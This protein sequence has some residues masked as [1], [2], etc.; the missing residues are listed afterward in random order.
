VAAPAPQQDDGFRQRYL[1]ALKFLQQ[2]QAPM[3]PEPVAPPA[4]KESF[5]QNAAGPAAAVL[6]N[7]RPAVLPGRGHQAANILSAIAQIYGGAQQNMLEQKRKDYSTQAAQ[8]RADMAERR[9]QQ[10]AGPEALRLD[11]A[12]R[13]A[14]GPKQ[15]SGEDWIDVTPDVIGWAKKNNIE[16]YPGLKRV[17]W[18]DLTRNMSQVNPVYEELARLRL[19]QS[20]RARDEE[21][22]TVDDSIED[23]AN[24][25]RSPLIP[26]RN[27][28]RDAIIS[29]VNKALAG[30]DAPKHSDGTPYTQGELETL[31]NNKE[32]FNRTG[33]S[34]RF[35]ATRI[36][37][38]TLARH[39]TSLENFYN[40]YKDKYEERL[41]RASI[42]NPKEYIILQKGLLVAARN[43]LL[44]KDAVAP[45]NRLATAAAKVARESATVFAG[46]YA[47]EKSEI[48]EANRSVAAAIGPEGH[49][50]QMEALK[51]LVLGRIESMINIDPFMGTDNP[52]LLDINPIRGWEEGAA[53][54][55]TFKKDE[56]G[57]PEKRNTK[58]GQTGA[59]KWGKKP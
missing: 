33:N 41:G 34:Q 15:T 14:E 3:G 1:E 17:K 51:E 39:I 31:W 36:A 10:M 47:P 9:K 24:F 2:T 18:S 46:G 49:R 57:A 45:A 27:K 58:S 37:A 48:D 53:T 12:K 7:M 38:N 25:R 11:M 5:W 59:N 50:G 19:E 32:A 56:G 16:I 42:L 4:P 43:G 29:G 44:G 8:Y 20:R 21:Q 22:A 28:N 30:P 26:A 35:T 54:A 13:I 23:M 6:G 55:E 52:Y 40:A